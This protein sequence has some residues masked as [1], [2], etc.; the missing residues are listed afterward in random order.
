VQLGVTL[1][2]MGPESTRE[3]MS[4]CARAAE[5]A[6]FESLWIT[7][8]VA[9]PP[10]DAEGSGGRYVDPLVTLAWM[11]GFTTRIRLGTGVIILPYRPA[12]PF[13]KSVAALQELSDGRLLLGVGVGWMAAEFK[14][15][16]VDMGGRGR[17][18]D[19]T[20]DFLLRCFA[21]DEVEAN[22]QRFLFKPRPPRPPLLVGGRPPHA[23]ERAARYGDGWLPMARAPADVRAGIEQYHALTA[24]MGRARGTVSVFSAI[25]FQDR[26]RGAETIA[27][28]RESGIDRLVCALRYRTVDEYRRGLDG[29][30]MLR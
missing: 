22:G 28:W 26:V 18:T 27:A 20:L 19:A 11:A 4:A 21:S 12:L 8:H 7:D 16:G 2:N 29:L 30:A 10:D 15:L 25:E 14:A 5:E 6:G 23:V 1:R 9:I 13:A 17:I 3:T 24:A